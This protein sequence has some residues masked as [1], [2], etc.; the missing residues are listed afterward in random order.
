MKSFPARPAVRQK[1]W[2]GF[3]SALVLLALSGAAMAGLDIVNSS[4]E[5]EGPVYVLKDMATGK[6]LGTF[7]DLEKEQSDYGYESS[8]VPDFVWSK[9]RSYVAV[10]LGASRSRGVTLY[11]VVGKS[12]KNIE[13]PQLNKEQAGPIDAIT[14][15]SAEGTDAVRWQPDGTLLLRFWAAGRVTSDT[16]DRKEANVWADVAITGT[17]TVI[18]GTSL[19]EPSP[20]PDA[21]PEGDQ[22]FG[23]ER[24]VGTHQ[25]TGRNPDGTAYKGS[26]EIRVVKGVVGVAWKIGK[27]VS[28][29]QGVL[30]G[31]TL[32][33]AL[34]SGV[35]IYKLVGQSEGQS[36]IG[37]WSGAG[38]ATTNHEAVLIGN[39]GLTTA[40]FGPSAVNG[41]YLSLR[42]VGD[43][44]IESTVTIS[45]DKPARQ[46]LWNGNGKKTKCQAIALGD[47]LAILTPTGLSV[48]EKQTDNSGGVPLV[49]TAL[50]HDGKTWQETLSPAE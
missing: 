17:K 12:L 35:A 6:V 5:G 42:E 40:Q 3:V 49:G 43:S 24:L 27:T 45:G 2:P 21:A 30:V 34:D 10:S 26:M 18:V 32:G 14:D 41:K 37:L 47:G 28:H 29:G 20:P 13:L 48:Y 23:P 16:E 33:V 39:A 4:P 31:G 11:K 1:R 36:L 46:V 7:W 19:A 22:A 50:T 44:Q 15:T 8:I 25:V 9:D 38:S